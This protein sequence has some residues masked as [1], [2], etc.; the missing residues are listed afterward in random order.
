MHPCLLVIDRLVNSIDYSHPVSLLVMS[1]ARTSLPLHCLLLWNKLSVQAL[2]R[3]YDVTVPVQRRGCPYLPL[4]SHTKLNIHH[5]V[6]AQVTYERGQWCPRS[7]HE[8]CI[9]M[10]TR[11]K[12]MYG[13]ARTIEEYV[14]NVSTSPLDTPFSSVH[15]STNYLQMTKLQYVNSSTTIELQIKNDKRYINPY[16]PEY[17]QTKQNR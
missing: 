7:D 1:R 5:T 16:L 14:G 9:L 11:G 10:L 3:E 15:G 12:E 13:W 8:K 17:Q 2:Y 6:Q 4:P